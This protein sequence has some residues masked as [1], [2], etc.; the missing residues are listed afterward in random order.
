MNNS[1]YQNRQTGFSLLELIVVVILI[2]VLSAVL[3]Q[4][5]FKMRHSA[6]ILVLKGSKLSLEGAAN[7]IYS[8][9]LAAG[10]DNQLSGMVSIHSAHPLT[11]DSANNLFAVATRY[12][13]PQ[14][15][16]AE[17]IKISELDPQKWHY[18]N[19][20]SA[21]EQQPAAVVLWTAQGPGSLANCNIRYQE[22]IAEGY[23]PQISINDAGC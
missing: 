15:V 2:A 11:A 19:Q 5:Y 18:S 6:N 12:G 10:S 8:K 1:K 7:L 13:Y 22:A 23:R 9:S 3:L 21:A 20:P 16:W 14:G 4:K 17:M